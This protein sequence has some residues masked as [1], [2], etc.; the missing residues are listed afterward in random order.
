MSIKECRNCKNWATNPQGCIQEY[1]KK[2]EREWL[3]EDFENW[4]HSIAEECKYFEVRANNKKKDADKLISL[5]L[6]QCE[7]FHDKYNDGYAA[8]QYGDSYEVIPIC[9]K[10][11]RKWLSYKFYDVVGKS[12]S[13]ETLNMAINTIEGIAIHEGGKYPLSVRIA[14]NEKEIYYDLGDENWDII[15]I[16]P[17]GWEIKPHNNIIFERFNVTLPA[18]KPAE[19]GNINLIWKYCY[20]KEGDKLL[21]IVAIISFL[22]PGIPH[23]I[24]VVYGR[25]GRAKT[26]TCKVVRR[27][28]DKLSIDFQRFPKN[29]RDA[30]IIFSSRWVIALDNVSNIPDWLSDFLCR[31]VTGEGFETREL[32]TDKDTVP[33]SYRRC[34]IINGIAIPALKPDA[35]DRCLFFEGEIISEDKRKEEAQLWREFE[36]DAPYIFRAMLDT[37]PKA[38]SILP[39]VRAELKRLPRMADFCVWGEAIARALGYSPFEFY[40]SYMSRIRD[41]KIEAVEKTIIGELL[42]K[43]MKNE[44][45]W[46]GEPS[47]LFAE[48]RDLANALGLKKF[49]KNTSA[50]QC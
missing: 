33:F 11:F 47:E 17:E 48:L 40:N 29:E 3:K 16:T 32:Y 1:P 12:P 14:G 7:L 41:Q 27:L 34:I 4:D 2:Q 25:E 22:I 38:M 23:P 49:P 37:I 15:K 46:E 26:F 28:I 18:I 19:N 45:K 21:F 35:I 6:N 44:D 39:E 9:S 24:L 8:I 5:V 30:A 10:I 20:I 50:F 42:L 36:K 31:A 13:S 43:Y